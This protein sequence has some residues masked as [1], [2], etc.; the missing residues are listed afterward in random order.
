MR[1]MRNNGYFLTLIF[2]SQLIMGGSTHSTFNYNFG[3]AYSEAG[4][5][6]ARVL[7]FMQSTNPSLYKTYMVK[8]ENKHVELI[9]PALLLHHYAGNRNKKEQQAYNES[10]SWL[11]GS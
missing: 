8:Y 5:R 2:L 4:L 6:I 3:K 9:K 1:H 7:I 10:I 11:L